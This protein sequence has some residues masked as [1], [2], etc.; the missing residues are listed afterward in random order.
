[1]INKVSRMAA[2]LLLA[3]GVLGLATPAFADEPDQT[4]P[5]SSPVPL[6]GPVED[7]LQGIP[8]CC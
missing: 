8:G 2:A 5:V 3:V 1:M 4:Q 7:L 6:P